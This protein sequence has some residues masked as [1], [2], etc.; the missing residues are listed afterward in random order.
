ML[1]G[2]L[3]RG[4]MLIAGSAEPARTRNAVARAV[5]AMLAGLAKG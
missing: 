2:A 4:A 1:L 5:G 3:V